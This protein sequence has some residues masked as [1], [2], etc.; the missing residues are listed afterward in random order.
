MVDISNIFYQL[1]QSAVNLEDQQREPL[2]FSTAQDYIMNGAQDNNNHN[3]DPK[4]LIPGSSNMWC[5]EPM[6]QL[7]ELY[8]EK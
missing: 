2:C 8:Q 3:F 7:E 1:K 5:G 6:Q 4:R